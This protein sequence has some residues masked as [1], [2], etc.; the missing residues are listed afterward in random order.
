[1][2]NKLSNKKSNEI[3]LSVLEGA[4]SR[5]NIK[6]LL[7]HRNYLIDGAIGGKTILVKVCKPHS[8]TELGHAYLKATKT[9]A[10]SFFSSVDDECI[11]AVEYDDLDVPSYANF[12]VQ[13]LTKISNLLFVIEKW[14]EVL[15]ERMADE[16]AAFL[17]VGTVP[18]AN[19]PRS[20]E[21]V[22]VEP[23]RDARATHHALFSAHA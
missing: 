6:I 11:L 10:P 23:P 7:Y 8:N 19:A 1:M 16:C 22:V 12:Q 3:V 15:Q 13:C 14:V 9:E 4:F 18:V 5:K 20:R 21:V 17:D 2:D